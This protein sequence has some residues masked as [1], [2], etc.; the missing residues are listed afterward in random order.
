MLRTKEVQIAMAAA[1]LAAVAS[2]VFAAQSPACWN[3]REFFCD[4]GQERERPSAQVGGG[5]SPTGGEPEP[6]PDTDTNTGE[7]PID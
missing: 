7:Q 6:E 2:P 4:H 3:K 1:L 5:Q